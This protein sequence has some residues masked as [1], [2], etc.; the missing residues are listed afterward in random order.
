MQQNSNAK[1]GLGFIKKAGWNALKSV[2]DADL[3][4]GARFGHSLGGDATAIAL[5][6]TLKDISRTIKDMPVKHITLP[7]TKQAIFSV[8]TT[9]VQKQGSSIILG[10]DYF[11]SFGSLYIPKHIWDAMTQF[12]VWIE[13]ALLNEWVSQMQK[14]GDNKTKAYSRNDYYHALHW[15]TPKRS[16]SKVRS[17]VDELLNIEKIRCVWSSKKITKSTGYAVDHAFPFARWPN[18][19]LWN[20]VPTKTQVNAK[21]SDKLPSATKL[22]TC[23]GDIV[24][25]WQLAW[26]KDSSEFFTQAALALPSLQANNTNFDDV[27][28]AFS[29]QRNRIRELQQLTEWQ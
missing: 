24:N 14:Y 2:G 4:L 7:G 17:R 19:D 21:K 27:F 10:G 15:D 22:R 29:L 6:H 3:Y 5:Q 28:E 16:T 12:S 18:N 25:W 1:S 11:A 9:L 20:L 26:G 23:R 13:P 8:E